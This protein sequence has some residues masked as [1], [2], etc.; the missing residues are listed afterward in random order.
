MFGTDASIRDF[1]RTFSF[2]NLDN[3]TS[4]GL[5]KKGT[6]DTF[7]NSFRRNQGCYT[8]LLLAMSINT[9]TETTLG[10]NSSRKVAT[11]TEW[12]CRIF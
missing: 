6:Q 8:P 12:I 9:Y 10:Q 1:Y 11:G 2:K 3:S 7:R 5:T 4:F